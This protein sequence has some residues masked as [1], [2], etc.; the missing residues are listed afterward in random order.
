MPF[1]IRKFLKAKKLD[2]DTGVCKPKKLKIWR[3]LTLRSASTKRSGSHRQEEM[4][5][6]RARN[7]VHQN[8]KNQRRSYSSAARRNRSK[9]IS[10]TPMQVRAIKEWRLLQSLQ[11]T[12]SFRRSGRRRRKGLEKGHWQPNSSRNTCSICG[13]AFEFFGNHKHHCRLCGSIVCDD[14]STGRDYFEGVKAKQRICDQCI[15]STAKDVMSLW[16]FNGINGSRVREQSC[17]GGTHVRKV[18]SGEKNVPEHTESLAVRLAR[19][20]MQAGRIS[21]AEFEAVVVGDARIASQSGA[22]PKEVGHIECIVASEPGMGRQGD[23]FDESTDETL[24]PLPASASADVRPRFIGVDAMDRLNSGAYRPWDAFSIDGLCNPGASMLGDSLSAA[25]IH[26]R[27]KRFG[28]R[29]WQK[30]WNIQQAM[31]G[32]QLFK[33]AVNDSQH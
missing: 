28:C 18:S 16:G 12:R 29:K 21:Q 24:K 32:L 11:M 14:C 25:L 30:L 19:Q 22:D 26:A 31:Q 8:A 20:A 3:K 17:T 27:R 23:A 10:G 6:R 1:G 4:F 33:S 13:D 15:D 7:G 9:T 5:P 2:R